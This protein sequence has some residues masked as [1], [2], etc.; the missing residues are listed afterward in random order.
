[1][2]AS[3]AIWAY[4]AAVLGPISKIISKGPT[5]FTSLMMAWASSLNDVATTTS[6][7]IGISRPSALAFSI[8]ALASL[9]KS[10]SYRDLPTGWPAAAMKVLAMPPPTIS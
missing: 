1:M 9:I 10:A 4:L 5:S 7:G 6:I 3:L 2:P 8:M